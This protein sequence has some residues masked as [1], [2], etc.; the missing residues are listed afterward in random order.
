MR[1]LSMASA[2]RRNDTGLIV[3]VP[4]KNGKVKR[5]LPT[6][7]PRSRV[8]TRWRV[9]ITKSSLVEKRA[10][11]PLPDLDAADTIRHA[12]G[13]VSDTGHKRI[14]FRIIGGCEIVRAATAASVAVLF[15]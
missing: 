11:V 15:L 14:D 4:A 7:G 5:I 10:A 13:D 2:T 1:P 6:V 8:R 12:P 3:T 9:V